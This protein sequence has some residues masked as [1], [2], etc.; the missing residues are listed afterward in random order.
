[1]R[2]SQRAMARTVVLETDLLQEIS[3][4]GVRP[5]DQESMAGSKTRVQYCWERSI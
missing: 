5:S 3:G 2:I 4:L 1:M